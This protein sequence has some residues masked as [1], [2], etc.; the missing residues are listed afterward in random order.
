MDGGHSRSAPPP[1]VA[2]VASQLS[3]TQRRTRL[4]YSAR[5]SLKRRAASLFAGEAGFG[6]CSMLW[7]EASSAA[8]S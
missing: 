1:P 8:T 3:S 5:F 2:P 6:S 7:I 4:S